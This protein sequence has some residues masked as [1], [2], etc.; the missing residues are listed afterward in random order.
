MSPK[1]RSWAGMSRNLNLTFTSII[2]ISTLHVKPANAA[3]LNFLQ[4]FPTISTLNHL[5]HAKE[6]FTS[7][8]L[9]RLRDW[10]EPN[11]KWAVLSSTELHLTQFQWT[12]AAGLISEILFLPVLGCVGRALASS[13]QHTKR[14]PCGPFCSL[15][16]VA[17]LRAIHSFGKCVS[18]RC[19]WLKWRQHSRNSHMRQW[20][21][22]NYSSLLEWQYVTR[23]G[24]E[25]GAH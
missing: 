4:S 17:L 1:G 11:R 25:F 19:A 8:L 13:M 6:I 21:L 5:A 9:I 12:V 10:T 7:L 16:C 14:L 15:L 3:M 22:T 18:W 2:A 20:I 24:I 23:E